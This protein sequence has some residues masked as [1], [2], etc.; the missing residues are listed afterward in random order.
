LTTILYILILLI[1]D[2]SYTIVDPRI[3]AQFVTSSRRKKKSKS[4]AV[5]RD[6]RNTSERKPLEQESSGVSEP[7][8]LTQPVISETADV[9]C[10]YADAPP[11]ESF[12]SFCTREV[13]GDGTRLI[14]IGQEFVSGADG[15]NGAAEI[16]G[17]DV[18]VT[19]KYRKRSHLGE[20]IHHISHNKG[21]VIGLIII[22]VM[23][24]FA[25][26]SLF[27]NFE[28]IT[29]M[30]VSIRLTSPN[31]K[32]PFGTDSSG[33][34]MFLRVIYGSRY[35]LIIGLGAT[36]IQLVIGVAAGAVA[37]YFGGK[38]D[39]VIMRLTDI[40][41]SIPGLLLGI[42]VI[43][44]LGQSLGNLIL[45]VGITGIP[46]YVR[47]TRASLLTVKSNEFVE[48]ARAI[49]FSDIRVIASQVLPNGMAPIIVTITTSLGVVIVIAAS[50]SFL[51]FGVPVPHPEWGA[52]IANSKDLMHI[53][54]WLTTFPGLFI[55]LTVFG[56]NLL[57]DG[58]RDALDPKQ[59][60]A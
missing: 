21:A 18:P 42:V 46:I 20:L 58:L 41:A 31:W 14:A 29:K 45:A 55:M 47:I 43:T 59:R 22:A 17:D 7:I 32:F 53:A 56:F 11:P 49:G 10:V 57:G 50:L 52:L 38:L 37:G 60:K 54:P 16:P 40:L 19:K 15:E 5:H 33:R 48:A 51:G 30:N 24:V 12:E 8:S 13:S 27:M 1:V 23:V 4:A 35:S 26:A 9:L 44:T 36:L 39:D 25:V 28:S 34:N 3:K 2:L 6:D